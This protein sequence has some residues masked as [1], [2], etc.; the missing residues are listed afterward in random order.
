MLS[1]LDEESYLQKGKDENFM[2][3]LRKA[4]VRKVAPSPG[5]KVDRRSELPLLRACTDW[6]AGHKLSCSGTGGS[7]S[8][9]PA[10][11][12]APFAPSPDVERRIRVDGGRPIPCTGLDNIGNTC[13]INCAPPRLL[14]AGRAASALS[15]RRNMLPW[16]ARCNACC[17]RR[18]RGTT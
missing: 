11:V 12:W 16:Q 14:R 18:R 6:K 1:L 2:T 5:A 17:T 4:R 7:P 8:P 13:F 15:L 3:K 10:P 9:K